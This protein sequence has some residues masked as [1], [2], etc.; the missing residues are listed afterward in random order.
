[1]YIYHKNRYKVIGK[2]GAIATKRPGKDSYRRVYLIQ[3]LKEPEIL[4]G[5]RID[6]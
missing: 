2:G 6:E 1:M 4:R 3:L 5:R